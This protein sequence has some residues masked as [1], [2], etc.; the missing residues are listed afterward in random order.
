MLMTGASLLTRLDARDRALFTRWVCDTGTAARTRHAWRALTHM[1]GAST[2]IAFSTLPIATHGMLRAAALHALAILVI[3][4]LVVQV[5]KR[6]VGRPRPSRGVLVQTLVG[7]PDRFSFPSG[8]AAAAMSV[9]LA[10]AAAFPLLALPL[11]LLAVMVGV[12]RVCLGVHYPGDVIIGQ[13]I[14][15]ATGAAVLTA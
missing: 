1:G 4:H 13:L 15:L 11:L 3:S 7:E 10:Y 12:S 5:I 8:H 6:S 14:A 2:T 9:A